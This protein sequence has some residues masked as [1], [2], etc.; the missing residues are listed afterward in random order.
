MNTLKAIADLARALE[1]QGKDE[2]VS[3]R[4]VQLLSLRERFPGPDSE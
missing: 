4:D 3:A 1:L 2:A